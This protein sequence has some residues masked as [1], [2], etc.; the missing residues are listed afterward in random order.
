MSRPLLSSETALLFSDLDST[1]IFS[2]RHPH[3]EDCVWVEELNGKQ[4]S[5]MTDGAYRFFAEQSRLRVVPVTT[6]DR[7]QYGR[8]GALADT[9]GWEHALICN[10]AVLLNGGSEDTEWRAESERLAA[11]A[12]P[13]LSELRRLAEDKDGTEAVICSEPFMFYV[14]AEN[15]GET[16]DLL[17]AAADPGLIA[18]YRDSRKVYCIPQPLSKGRAVQRYS[19]RFGCESFMAAGDSAFDISMLN[20]ADLSFCPEELA[21]QVRTNGRLIPCS[22]SFADTLCDMLEKITA[23][24]ILP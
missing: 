3:G 18:V 21:Q 1:L 16:Y 24:E 9:M 2:H 15:A 19:A 7:R 13:H 17:L 4:Q 20:A 23:K 11:P 8:L 6:R 12:L 14:R 10:G 5:F 22:G